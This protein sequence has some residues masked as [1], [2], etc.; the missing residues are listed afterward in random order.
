MNHRKRQPTKPKRYFTNV[1]TEN[2]APLSTGP[3]EDEAPTRTCDSMKT[4]IEDFKNIE[5]HKM[6]LR[7]IEISEVAVLLGKRDNSILGVA[8]LNECKDES[9]EVKKQLYDHITS[10]Q[11][12]QSTETVKLFRQFM[13]EIKHEVHERMHG[14]A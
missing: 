6:A 9:V 13:Q 12:K 1:K 3:W 11:Q 14:K 2:L 4:S 7:F 8:L 5:G 10:S